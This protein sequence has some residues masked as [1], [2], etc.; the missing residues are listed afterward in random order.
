MICDNE[1]VYDYQV[2]NAKL[3][4]TIRRIERLIGTESDAKETGHKG[5]SAFGPKT[6]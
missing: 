6:A 1:N 5:V 3:E 2:H 4:L